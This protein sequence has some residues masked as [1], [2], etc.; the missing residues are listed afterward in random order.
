MRAP[1][2]LLTRLFA[3]DAMIAVFGEE[4]AIASWLQVEVA[5]AQAQAQ[6]GVLSKQAAAAVEAAAQLENIDRDR[7]WEEARNVGYPILPL[8]RMIAAALPRDADSRVHYGATTQDIMDSGLALQLRDATARLVQL[9]QT[10]GDAIALLVE[11]HRGT[12]LAA[13]THG[14][15]AVPTTFGAKMAVLLAEVSR[16]RARLI[17]VAPRI[18]RISLFGAGGTSAALGEHAAE[19]RAAMAARLGLEVTNVPW[20][21]ARDSVAEF[22]HVCVGLSATCA[23]FAREVIDLAR[24]EIG[25]VG[26]PDGHHR[27]ASS[28]MPQKANPIASE[29]VVGMSVTASALS[30]ALGRAMEAGHERSAG[31]WQ[32]EWEVIPQLAILAAGCAR[33]AGEIA[34]G[35]RVFDGA[36][37]RNLGGEGYVMAEAYMMHLAADL[38]RERAHDLVYAAVREARE[39]GEPLELV[40]SRRSEHDGGAPIAPIAPEEY[41]GDCDLVCDGALAEWRAAAVAA[42]PT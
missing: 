36:M 14:Q 7:L 4:R 39:R 1:F 22:G 38:G 27:G 33:R 5:L 34:E 20:H 16:H 21:V 2:P 6:V 42:N 12:V 19:I 25:E 18:S 8:V 17:S 11:K 26:E 13:R 28:T 31:E 3:D 9:T 15:Q 37:R 35:L 23:R 32:V 10:F 24:T 40:V 41:L 30:A 29:A